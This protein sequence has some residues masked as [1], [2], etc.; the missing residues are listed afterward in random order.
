[1]P[2]NVTITDDERAAIKRLRISNPK[3]TYRE[4]GAI[5]SIT[6]GAVCQVI[7]D[8]RY[9]YIAKPRSMEQIAVAHPIGPNPQPKDSSIRA[10]TPSQ[11]MAGNGRV[12]RSPRRDAA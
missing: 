9:K 2:R 12:C 3:M 5:F 11:L 1:M 7:G 10:L 8:T 4:I 6:A